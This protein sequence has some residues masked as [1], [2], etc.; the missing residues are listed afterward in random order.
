MRKAWIAAPIVGLVAGVGA[1]AWSSQS[2]S[3]GSSDADTYRQL[4]LFTDVVDQVRANYVRPIDTEKAVAAALNGMLS[5]L[6]PHSSYLTPQEYRDSRTQMQ[7]S[8]GGLGIEVTTEDGVVKVVSPMDD[9]PAS[10]AGIQV[11]DYIT[12]L[13]DESLIGL[14]LNEA[15]QRMRGPIGTTITLTLAREGSEPID[16][17]LTREKIDVRAVTARVED[18]IGILRVSTF[19]D[20]TTDMLRDGIAKIRREAG[21]ALSGVVLDLRNNSGGLLDQ[22]VAV[23][24]AFLD[25][26]VIVTTK[27]RGDIVR[28]RYNARRGDMLEGVPMVVLINGGSA[29]ASEIVAGA[30]QDHGRALVVG[31]TSFGKGSVQSVQALN[32]GRDGA[33][34]IT[35]ALYYTPADRS[36]QNSGIEPDLEIAQVRGK[37]DSVARRL[38]EADLARS[39]T[40]TTGAKRRGPHQ[41]DEEPPENWDVKQDFQM[42]RAKQ[43]LQQGEVAERLKARSAG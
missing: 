33:L 43:L 36:I 28:D 40:N 19:N 24:D 7:G 22:S 39:L 11:G 15:V 9:T 34:R 18:N 13:N 41:P 35:T 29:S 17:T 5:S 30:L 1:M 14:T 25:A 12:H 20:K 27:G 37:A 6:D 10:R 16:V 31:M 4:R 8:Y 38:S 3:A 23:A 21:S 32:G 2:S 26:G 42:S